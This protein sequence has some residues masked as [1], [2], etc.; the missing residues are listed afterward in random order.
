[1]FIYIYIWWVLLVLDEFL[2]EKPSSI[3][4]DVASRETDKKRDE[5]GRRR[6]VAPSYYFKRN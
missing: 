3:F 5:G 2:L 4:Y 1:M 6:R